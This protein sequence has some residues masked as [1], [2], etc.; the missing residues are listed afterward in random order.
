MELIKIENLKVNPNNPRIIKDDNFKKLVLSIKEFPEMLQ[1]RPIVVNEEM[2]ILGGN[3]RYRA[4]IEAGKKEVP[5]II[6]KGLSEEKQ[7]EFLIKDNVSGGEWDYDI[8]A[9]E[10]SELPITEWGVN[11]WSPNDDLFS[12]DEEDEEEI[13]AGS[14][15]PKAS[16]DG[17]SIFEMVMEHENKIVLVE[18]LNKVKKEYA[19]E[20]LEDA[21]MEV[22]RIYK[23]N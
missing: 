4:C 17:F 12:I 7:K 2:V 6:A 19:F 5:V 11:V 8:L 20:K 1:L 23:K 10:W 14:K 9:N 3:M 16:D 22:V 13:S 21:L 18:L 15:E